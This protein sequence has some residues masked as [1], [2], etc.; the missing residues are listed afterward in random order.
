MLSNA[1][2]GIRLVAFAWVASTLTRDPV[3][4]AGVAAAAQLPWL[5][6]SAHAGVVIDRFDRRRLMLA[7]HVVH[8]GTGLLLGLLILSDKLSLGALVALAAVAGCAELLIDT[9]GQTLLPALVG[10]TQVVRASGYLIAAE[11]STQMLVGRPLGG[12][13]AEVSTGVA[14]LALSLLAIG[15]AVALLRIPARLL[16]RAGLPKESAPSITRDLLEGLRWL[17]AHH[18][19]RDVGM[20]VAV[21][22]LAYGATVAIFVLFAR[23]LLGVGALGFG[24]LGSCVACGGVLGSVVAAPLAARLGERGA[25]LLVIFATAAALATIG[26][27]SNVVV[28]A[29]MLA[30]VGGG[31]TIW[32][33]VWRGMR[34]RFVPD[35]LLG[36]VTSLLR[37]LEM[38]PFPL[39][40]LLGGVIVALGTTLDDRELGLRLPYLVTAATFVVLGVVLHPVMSPRRLRA[41]DAGARV[42]KSQTAGD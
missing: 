29:S 16:P 30:F 4:V 2:D 20:I 17:W 11:V 13:L 22:N 23:E 35:H 39:A 9:A 31:F 19:L 18:L 7:G 25:F 12:L 32:E 10:K 38:G 37:C 40:S 42:G 14:F 5:L 33:V 36:R 34:V 1:A 15:S 3:A 24:V 6:A 21:S 27:S 28:V 41:A 26:L 8:L